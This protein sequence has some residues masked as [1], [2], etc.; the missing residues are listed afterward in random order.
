MGLTI[1]EDTRQQ[2]HGRGDK[3]AA[4]HEAWAA[5][6]VG[7][8]RSKLAFGDYALPPAVSVDTK[9]SIQELAANVQGDHDR[10]RRE[11]AAA[12]DAGCELVILT[13]NAHGIRS[14]ADLEE[15]IEPEFEFKKRKN[16]KKRIIGARLAKACATMHE[17][18][19]AL[20][21]FCA[22]EESAEMIV[23]ILLSKGGGGGERADGR[24]A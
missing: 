9:R 4:K 6:G 12:R 11:L 13:E 19:G 5:A 17:R 16:A 8:I 1:I 2:L 23:R 15:W 18:Y 20:F 21:A 24:R 3:H 14:L 22:P 10:F 7:L